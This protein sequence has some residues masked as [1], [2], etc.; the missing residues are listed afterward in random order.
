MLRVG[1]ARTARST[2]GRCA[3]SP[4]SGARY[5]KGYGHFTTRQNLQYNWPKL[6]DDARHP[7]A[8]SPRSRCTPSRPAATASATSPSDQYAGA[9][10]D[11]VED[12]RIW[13]EIVRQWS[14]LHPEFSFLPRKFKIAITGCEQRPRRGQGP[15]HRP[16][17][18]ARRRRRSRLRGRSSAAASDARP[19]SARR[20]AS[21]CRSR[22]CS[23][24]S[25]RSCASTTSY[26]RRDNKY[27][28]R[29]K[30]TGPRDRRRGVH[31]PRR[32]GVGGDQGL[33]A[34]AARRR[35][36][37]GS[38]LISPRRPSAPSRMRRRRPTRG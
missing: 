33:D 32:G 35:R 5:D 24:T 22:I 9:A 30:V 12:P 26:G 15:R 29:I 11:E 36:W 38:R 2:R 21:S 6:E 23:P 31:A 13:C 18:E 8:S 16:D 10:A 7:G 28:A 34:E 14:T 20:F 3:S 27:K 25:R 37:I 19:S 1:D 17:H 4:T